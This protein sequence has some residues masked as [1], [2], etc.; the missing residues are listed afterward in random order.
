MIWQL[1]P[2]GGR[3]L[4]TYIDIAYIHVVIISSGGIRVKKILKK[5]SGRRSA[6]VPHV[7]PQNPARKLY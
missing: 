6:M 5:F 3:A 2:R 1:A 7:I 4:R